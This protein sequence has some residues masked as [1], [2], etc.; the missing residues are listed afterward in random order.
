MK[1]VLELAKEFPTLKLEITAEDLEG[2]MRKVVAEIIERYENAEQSE[3]YVTRKRTAE[4]LD[5]DLST[6][7]R[8]DKIG[9]LQPVQIGG[10]RRY[11][12]S[13]IDKILAGGGVR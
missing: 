5:V 9:Y 3:T 13:D 11:K 6:L 7:W 4:M 1:N 2:M 12:Q 8:Y 10:K